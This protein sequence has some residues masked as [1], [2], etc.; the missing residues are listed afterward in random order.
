MCYLKGERVSTYNLELFLHLKCLDVVRK[1]KRTRAPIF[2]A[3]TPSDGS[4]AL[5]YFRFN[6]ILVPSFPVSKIDFDD[7]SGPLFSLDMKNI[8]RES[9][10]HLKASSIMGWAEDFES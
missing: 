3:D 2:T 8:K 9:N 1:A 4:L 7:F 5:S 6:E 10:D